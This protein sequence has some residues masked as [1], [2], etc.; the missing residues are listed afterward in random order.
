MVRPILEYACNVW[1][2]HYN[3][4]IQLIEAVQRRAAR[5]CMNCYSTYESVT[6]MLEKLKWPTLTD[7]R[8][9]LK[10]VMMHV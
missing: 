8:D 3:K 7:R 10:L 5:F 9:D 4:D 1:C 2:P 6:S